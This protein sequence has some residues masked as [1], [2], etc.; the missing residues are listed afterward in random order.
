MLMEV[1]RLLLLLL[2]SSVLL[3]QVISPGLGLSQSWCIL[4]S[5]LT[6]PGNPIRPA[7]WNSDGS[8]EPHQASLLGG[9]S[10]LRAIEREPRKPQILLPPIILL[11]SLSDLETM[12]TS[13]GTGQG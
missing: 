1:D 3:V 6:A 2:V 10:P 5:L 9:L 7:S 8:R 11:Q 4:Q 12:L 13:K